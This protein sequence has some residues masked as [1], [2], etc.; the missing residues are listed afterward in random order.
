MII[1]GSLK[2]DKSYTNNSNH[3]I[4]IPSVVDEYFSVDN[5]LKLDY[6]TN[7]NYNQLAEKGYNIDDERKFAVELFFEYIYDDSNK[8]IDDLKYNFFEN[9]HR[10]FLYAKTMCQDLLDNGVHHPLGV[11]A[12]N[13]LVLGSNSEKFTM[14][15]GWRI[16]SDDL[17]IFMYSGCARLRYFKL[18]G[19]E[20]VPVFLQSVDSHNIN[21]DGQAIRIDSIDKLK[22][23]YSDSVLYDTQFYQEEK[24]FY[25][26]KH[27]LDEK[28]QSFNKLT[29]KTFGVDLEKECLSHLVC[30]DINNDHKVNGW[31]GE[32]ILKYNRILKNSFPLKVYIG[33]CKSENSKEFIDCKN[34]ILNSI[35][36]QKVDIEFRFI[37]EISDI[38]K[39]NE[40]KGFAF[41]TD[42]NVKW[43]TNILE[44]F[45]FTHSTK[46]I[47]NYKDGVLII[48]CEFEK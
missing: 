45:Y 37:D 27:Q 41:Y 13:P 24:F 4:K 20:Y 30:C 35:S 29:D 21:W 26:M 19:W 8:S 33:K 12:L 14:D 10:S 39:K 28:N 11:I 36:K 38:S 15:T 3:T 32:D 2:M 16:L 47:T 46:N 48:N 31:N 18:L 44:L 43:D 5:N 42:S 9:S 7:F 23:D 22:S 6:Y 17:V 1:I 40:K 34:R 25:F